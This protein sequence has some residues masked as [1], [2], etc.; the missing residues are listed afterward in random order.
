MKYIYSLLVFVLLFSLNASGQYYTYRY[1]AYSGMNAD[2]LNLA[3]DHAKK[4]ERSGKIWTAVGS[5]MFIGGAVMTY[6]GISSLTEDTNFTTFGIG[7]G[8]MCFGAF[9]LGYG[10]VAWLTGHEKVNSL[11]IELLAFDAGN[12][13]IKQTQYGL[14]LVLDF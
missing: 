9:P 1:N 6:T 8:V 12:L 13:N 2:Q 10:F 14:G 7:L 4:Q 3:I 11:E 5:G